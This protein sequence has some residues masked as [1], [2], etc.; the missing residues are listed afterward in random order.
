[1]GLGGDARANGGGLHGENAGAAG[2]CVWE[3][4]D[5][6][7]E[8]G[9]CICKGDGGAAGRAADLRGWVWPP[10]VSYEATGYKFG[11]GCYLWITVALTSTTTASSS[12][13]SQS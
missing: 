5:G 10:I 2:D 3:V 1:M 7:S 11:S 9:E 12:K 6:E 13:L 8:L 4:L